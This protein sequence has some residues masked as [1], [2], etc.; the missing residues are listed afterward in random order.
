VIA[1]KILILA[2][3]T[4]VVLVV[5]GGLGFQAWRASRSPHAPTS[6]APT[7]GAVQQVPVAIVAGQPIRLG[8][9]APVTMDLYE[10]FHCPH[11][12][13]FEEKFGATLAAAQQRGQLQIALYPMAFIDAGSTSAANAMACAAEAGFGSTYYLGLFANHTLQWNDDQLVELG[14]VVG[15]SPTRAFTT[16]VTGRSH[17]G[18]VDSI[19]ATADRNGVTSTPTLFIDG[20]A[21]DLSALT[22]ETLDQ[23]IAD[24]AKK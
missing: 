19:N 15:A 9:A 21:I 11:C 10:D 23:M 24:A 5:G 4:V 13:D 2:M 1:R 18:W 16:C 17:Q 8:A 14:S 3:L 12:A 20:S 7:V 22:P 6:S